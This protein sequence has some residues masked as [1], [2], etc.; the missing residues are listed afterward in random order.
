MQVTEIKSSTITD[1]KEFEPK[2]TDFGLAKSFEYDNKTRTSVLVGTPS[3][4][5]PEQISCPDDWAKPAVDVYALGVILYELLT[6]RIPFEAKST[7]ELFKKIET[8]DRC[9]RR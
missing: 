7:F 2:I 5:A 1:L 8:H 9:R 4:M 6:G 3:Y